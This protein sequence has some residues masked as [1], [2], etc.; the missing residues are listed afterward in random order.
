MIK[1]YIIEASNEGSRNG[2]DVELAVTT[3]SLK[4]LL[5]PVEWGGVEKPMQSK[6]QRHFAILSACIG[7]VRWTDTTFFYTAYTGLVASAFG[8]RPN[9]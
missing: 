6:Q 1:E 8:D 2:S 7:I 5:K 4:K 3:P 9:V